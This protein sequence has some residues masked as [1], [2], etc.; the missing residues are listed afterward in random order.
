AFQNLLSRFNTDDSL[1]IADHH[2]VGV[3]PEGGPENVISRAHVRYPIAHCFADCLFQRRLSRGHRY[4]FDAKKLHA[5][6]IQGLPFH[7]DLAHVDHAFTAEPRGDSSGGYPVLSRAGLG[8][9][10][11]FAHSLGKEDLAKRII[12]LVRAGMEQIFTLEKNSCAAESV[13]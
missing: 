12:D 8:D 1:K 5:D 7:V 3:R 11:P 6:D 2:R 9:D 10:A 13:R 4:D